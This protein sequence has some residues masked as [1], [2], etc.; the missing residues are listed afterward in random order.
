MQIEQPVVPSIR[1]VVISAEVVSSWRAVVSIINYLMKSNL[2]RYLHQGWV[3]PLNNFIS[4]FENTKNIK[5]LEFATEFKF[6]YKITFSTWLFHSLFIFLCSDVQ[7]YNLTTWPC[8]SSHHAYC[9]CNLDCGLSVASFWTNP[10]WRDYATG[11]GFLSSYLVPS[12][13]RLDIPFHWHD[14]AH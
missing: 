6:I 13:S 10:V 9:W 12:E 2:R 1:K 11:G 14:H 4:N 8:R 5:V 3:S 7:L